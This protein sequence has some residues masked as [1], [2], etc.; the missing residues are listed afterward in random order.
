[1]KSDEP[2]NS[3]EL[4]RE[5]LP[6]WR[7]TAPLPPRFAESV[8]QSIERA[9]AEAGVSLWTVLVN[10]AVQA[11]ARPALARAYV[12]V[13]LLMGLACGFWHARE[14]TARLDKSF[15][16]RYVQAVDPYQQASP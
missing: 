16:Q 1:M 2:M 3:V 14:T 13:L 15:A 7:V 4:L 12:V 8:W 11:M 5:W 10:C 9:E 6:A